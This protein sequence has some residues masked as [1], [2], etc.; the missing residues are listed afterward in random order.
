MKF[1]NIL[2]FTSILVSFFLSFWLHQSWNISA[3]LDS[4][5][6]VGLLLLVICAIMLLIEVE[7][8]VAFIKSSKYFFAR[9]SKKEQVIRESEKRPNHSVFYRKNFPSRKFFFQIGIIICA[10]SLL[11][12]TAIY[13]LGR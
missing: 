10:T 3:W 5:F 1:R 12:S 4:L 13:Y 2:F 6:L 11:F 8:F 9:V 7:F